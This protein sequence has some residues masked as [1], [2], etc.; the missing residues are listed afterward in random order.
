M[1][2]GVVEEQIDRALSIYTSQYG[3]VHEATIASKVYNYFNFAKNIIFYTILFFF[4][5]LWQDELCQYLS[6]HESSRVVQ[7]WFVLP[8]LYEFIVLVIV[9]HSEGRGDC[10]RSHCSEKENIW[11]G[12]SRGECRTTW[13]PM[14]IIMIHNPFYDGKY[15]ALEII[16]LR[17][18]SQCHCM[19]IG[20]SLV[21][22]PSNYLS[23]WRKDHTG[24]EI[25]WK[26]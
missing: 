6:S 7:S 9:S 22:A 20:W 5:I 11:G 1:F 15:P 12:Q 13:S 19:F 10:Q 14:Q 24:Q 25:S 21:Q 18:T 4:S 23:L 8:E 2:L 17:V 26:G 16:T 3:S